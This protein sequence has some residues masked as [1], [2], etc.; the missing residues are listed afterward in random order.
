MYHPRQYI[1]A[2]WRSPYRLVMI[3]FL[4]CPQ[5]NLWGIETFPGQGHIILLTMKH[6]VVM[7]LGD[8]GRSP[9]M[10]YHALS[11]LEEG[12]YVTLIGYAGESLIPPLEMALTGSTND[13]ASWSKPSYHGHLRVLRMEPYQL[14]KTYPLYRLLYYP[15]R[16]LS[17]SYCVI[18]TL[19]IRL[20]T[21]TKMPADI[22]LV[23]NPPSMPTLLLAYAYCVWQGIWR[24]HR[25]R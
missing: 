7:V 14:P 4:R 13:E 20:N 24:G 9:R 2:T 5:I 1:I 3:E 15:L 8:I 21:H 19:W 18:Y 10:Q 23:Q 12:H 17:L 11:L 25:P 16:L 22:I 6:A